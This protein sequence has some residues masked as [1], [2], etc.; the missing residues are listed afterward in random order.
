[1]LMWDD[2]EPD[3]KI[4][5]YDRG[6][7]IETKPETI[8][9]DDPQGK[10]Q[11]LISYRTGEMQVPVLGRTEALYSECVAFR[12]AILEDKPLINDGLAGLRV[13]LLLETTSQSQQRDGEWV[14]IDWSKYDEFLG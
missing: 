11:S 9:S 3:M 1:M 10:Y 2:V 13:V 4:K 6:I 14:Q 5:V 12:D 7:D 8:T